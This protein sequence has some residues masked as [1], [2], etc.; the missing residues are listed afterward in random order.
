MN[1]PF[2]SRKFQQVRGLRI[3]GGYDERHTDA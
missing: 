1:E 2:D 3:T